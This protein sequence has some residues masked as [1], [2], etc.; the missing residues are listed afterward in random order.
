MPICRTPRDAS[1]F[2]LHSDVML[3][4]PASEKGRF[5]NRGCGD[6]H[7]NGLLLQCMHAT[8]GIDWSGPHK[9]TSRWPACVD[10]DSAHACLESYQHLTWAPQTR[11]SA[12]GVVL[13]TL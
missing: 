3:T 1:R 6:H 2:V 5:G 13:G 10:D 4:K 8:P 11:P 9:A 12:G 7:A